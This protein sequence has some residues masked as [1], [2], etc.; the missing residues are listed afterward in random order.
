M[1]LIKWWNQLLDTVWVA[2]TRRKRIDLEGMGLT[3]IDPE[4]VWDEQPKGE[5]R[6]ESDDPRD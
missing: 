2:G 1:R 6:D 3:P 5:S 4:A